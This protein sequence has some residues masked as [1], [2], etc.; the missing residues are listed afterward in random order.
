MCIAT[1]FPGIPDI[2][3]LPQALC[4]LQSTSLD[5]ACYQKVIPS[6]GSSA[7]LSPYPA[8]A[9]RQDTTTTHHEQPCLGVLSPAWV[10]W[11]L[12]CKNWY[13]HENIVQ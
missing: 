1:C 8:N 10:A 2:H 6:L 13:C 11:N 7:L 4:C 12:T 9:A 3:T 5:N